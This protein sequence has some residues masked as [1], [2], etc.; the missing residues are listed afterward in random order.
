MP[1]PIEILLDPVSLMVFGLYVALI[2]WE[3]MRPARKLTVSPN[4]KLRGLLAFTLFFYL[5]SYLPLIWDQYLIQYQLF[6][7]SGLGVVTATVIG[8]LLYELAVYF[9]HRIMHR[10]NVLW[11]V[12]HQMHHSAE[13]LD[14]FGTFYFS[15]MDM[16][17]WTMLGS[18]CLTMLVGLPPQS[19]TLIILL[20]TFFSIFQHS[21]INTPQWLGYFIQRPESHSVHHARGVH[22]YNY[23][24]LPIF[25]MIFNTFKNPETFVNETGFYPGASTKVWDMIRFV[26]INRRIDT[27]AVPKVLTTQN[28]AQSL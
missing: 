3:V 6:D 10:F 8:L 2:F 24:D 14:T 11:R 5:S 4:W 13:R 16:L 22:A 28:I 27:N 20:T 12:F 21:N 9:W 7:L 23:S 17:G 1:T 18:L 26:D 25:D 19:V 15:P